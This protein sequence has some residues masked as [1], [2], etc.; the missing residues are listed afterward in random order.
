MLTCSSRGTRGQ[1]D[2]G[3]QTVAR[4]ERE[5]THVCVS[6]IVLAGNSCARSVM[7][8]EIALN[9]RASRRPATHRCLRTVE[10]ILLQL[11]RGV[12]GR[13]GA[14]A[15]RV[16]RSERA[17]SMRPTIHR[18]AVAGIAHAPLRMNAVEQ[19]SDGTYASFDHQAMPSTIEH[20]SGV[21]AFERQSLD[22]RPAAGGPANASAAGGAALARLRRRSES[23]RGARSSLQ[24]V[25]KS[26]HFSEPKPPS[27]ANR[28]KR[29]HAPNCC[30]SGMIA[31]PL[32][33]KTA[34]I[35]QGRAA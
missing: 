2:C 33:A 1:Y 35:D 23:W 28:V 7:R 34:L 5:R 19:R 4:L 17:R 11:L 31:L 10:Q 29:V 20:D 13:P 12:R 16:L 14:R 8:S 9:D 27:Y 30:H 18:A 24:S 15:R 25:E 32:I 22:K 26:R 6:R 21:T 3:Q